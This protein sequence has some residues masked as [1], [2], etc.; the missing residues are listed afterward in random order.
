LTVNGRLALLIFLRITLNE[1]HKLD[2]S[3]TAAAST[4]GSR[5]L[6]GWLAYERGGPLNK[7]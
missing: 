5:C 2:N 6:L 3:C 1:P 4:A 7:C